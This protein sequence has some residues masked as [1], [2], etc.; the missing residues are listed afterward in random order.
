MKILL[1]WGLAGLGGGAI[2]PLEVCE[3][4]CVVW[5]CGYLESVDEC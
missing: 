4:A 1:L 2:A 5:I 3:R